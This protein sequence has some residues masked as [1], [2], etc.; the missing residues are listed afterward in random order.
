MYLKC[1]LAA[2]MIIFFI[3]FSS[4]KEANALT[5]NQ[6]DY[7]EL[8]FSSINVVAASSFQAQ[9]GVSIDFQNS[10]FTTGEQLLLEAYEDFGD[11]T[12]VFSNLFNGIFDINDLGNDS[13][14]N[15][16]FS[17]VVPP[18]WS[19]DLD[20]Y[21]KITAETGSFQLKSVSYFSLD[22]ENRYLSS[23]QFP[24]LN[25]DGTLTAVPIPAT[26]PLSLVGFGALAWIARRRKT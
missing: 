20:G 1:K 24:K 11:S 3:V 22:G 18:L 19:V 6:G 17:Q 2:I 15:I 7:Y 16:G 4:N 9:G 25:L 23:V 8:S 10:T 12:P 13:D 26:L 5:L 14:V 21:F